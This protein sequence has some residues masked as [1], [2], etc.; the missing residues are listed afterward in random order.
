[1]CFFDSSRID[2]NY[3]F[4]FHYLVATASTR[5]AQNEVINSYSMRFAVALV[6]PSWTASFYMIQLL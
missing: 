5:F 3:D 2:S 1:M 4:W 6:G